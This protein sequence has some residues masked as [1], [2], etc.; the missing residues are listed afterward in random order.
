MSEWSA[1]DGIEPVLAARLWALRGD[2]LT[3][4]SLVKPLIWLPGLPMQARCTAPQAVRG[5]DHVPPVEDCYCGFWGLS[6][7]GSLEDVTWRSLEGWKV[8]GVSELW[9]RV[10]VGTRGWR[11]EVARP[12]A[13]VVSGRR[14]RAPQKV[15]DAVSARYG[16]PV[17]DRWPKLTPLPWWA[18]ERITA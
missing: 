17:L 1:P 18:A 14:R 13:L 7:P 16:I 8:S 15:L 2:D 5:D 11:A 9:G 4:R 6:S 10:V 12:A 3:L